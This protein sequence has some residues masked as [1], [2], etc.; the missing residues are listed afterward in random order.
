MTFLKLFNG[1]SKHGLDRL[2][3]PVVLMYHQI[4]DAEID[5][6]KL[7]V[8]PSNFEKQMYILKKS[9]LVV[10]LEDLIVQDDEKKL[11]PSIVLTFD[12]GYI[13]NFLAA[14]PILEKF[15]L[16]ATF[17][18]SSKHIG[19]KKEFWW[20]ELAGLL[21]LSRKLPRKITLSVNGDNQAFLL[22]GEEILDGSLFKKIKKW[23]YTQNPS[24]QR[25]QIC[26]DIWKLLSPLCYNEQQK[27]LGQLKEQVGIESKA[28]AEYCS[29]T[30]D[31]IVELAN[32]PLFSIGGHT[33]SHPFLTSVSDELQAYEIIQNKRYLENLTGL[34][35]NSFAYP[36]G[37]FNNTT[38]QILKQQGYK[39]A[40]TTKHQA[41]HGNCDI[42]QLGRVQ[43]DNW[44]EGQ[45]LKNLTRYSV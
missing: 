17:F 19:T 16:P 11:R 43:I 30:E 37:I 4:L 31:Q 12:D 15:E 44:N 26:M 45:F 21:L 22:T 24:T 40:F 18:I 35:I 41:I 23:K 42:Y 2:N 6:W 27:A 1:I 28:R 13:D 36:M 8:S 14:K 38:I 7:S 20:D 33:V 5:P 29:M 39:A 3:F 32:H 25:G 9:G 34:K 10:H